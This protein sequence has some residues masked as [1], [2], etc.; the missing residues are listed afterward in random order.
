MKGSARVIGMVFYFVFVGCFLGY[1]QKPPSLIKFAAGFIRRQ[2][3]K[4]L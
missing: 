4:I 3:I 1:A 2:L